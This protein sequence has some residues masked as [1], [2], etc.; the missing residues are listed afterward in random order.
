MALH[1]TVLGSSSA[2]PTLQRH[3]SAYILKSDKRKDFFLID[4][5]EGTQMLL[6][7]ANIR[8][9]R[10]SRIFISHLHGDHFFGVIGFV[11]TQN[12]FG[13]KDE[14]HI[15]AHKPLEKIIKLHLQ[16][17]NI[18]L[19][20]PLIFHALDT[21]KKRG[22]VLHEDETMKVSTFPLLHSITTH[23]FLFT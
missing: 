18:T 4:C 17:E 3:P 5:G 11:S 14:L 8:V 22:Y 13:R 23:G 1:L 21:R 16:I 15:Y 19:S 10:I 12:L 20:Y 2:T 6:K 9:Q 7:Q